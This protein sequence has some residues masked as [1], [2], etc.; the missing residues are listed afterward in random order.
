MQCTVTVEGRCRRNTRRQEDKSL[1]HAY[2][3]LLSDAEVKKK[4]GSG[5]N[6]DIGQLQ[7]LDILRKCLDDMGKRT[8]ADH[9]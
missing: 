1:C 5:K 9:S 8:D 7:Q 2:N 6:S 3:T 4:S